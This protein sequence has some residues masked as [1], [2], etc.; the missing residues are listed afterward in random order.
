MLKVSQL[1]DYRDWVEALLCW[2]TM[3][4]LTAMSSMPAEQFGTINE[5]NQPW[6]PVS[7]ADKDRENG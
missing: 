6:S 2:Q 7:L 1:S 4:V 5:K 3:L